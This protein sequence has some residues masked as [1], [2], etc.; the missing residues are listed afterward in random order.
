MTFLSDA[1]QGAPSTDQTNQGSTENWVEKVVSEKGEQWGDPQTLAKGYATSQEYIKQ[2]EQQASE[3]RE[4]L[5]KAKYGE[6]L[7]KE[8]RAQAPSATESSNST[9]EAS[10]TEDPA[11]TSQGV[12]EENLQSLIEQTLTQREAANT[13]KQNLEATDAK[14]TE[15]Y[16]TESSKVIEEK[17]RELG[18]S[19]ERLQA[20]ASESPNAFF[21]LIGEEAPKVSN[22]VTQG[23]VN[24]A[25]GF[26]TQS[27][28]QRNF[29]YYQ[30]LR[31][32]NSTKYYS[33][34]VQNQMMQ[35]RVALGDSFFN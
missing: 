14:L 3:L 24:T 19:K 34:K 23:T 9:P 5:T 15:L 17:G 28:A 27:S 1:N 30:K 25:A 26:D 10:S 4:D 6:E 13:A 31:R 20:I 18:M 8:I 35:D 22:P 12:S 29:Q 32:E 21:K 16:G 11:P 33:P 7:L 2:L